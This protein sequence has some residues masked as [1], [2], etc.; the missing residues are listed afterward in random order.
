M[1][2]RLSM[3]VG[4]PIARFAAVRGQAAF[5]QAPEI[6]VEVIS[7]SNPD[8]ELGQKKQL[9]FEA[10]AEEVW[11]CLQDGRMEFYEPSQPDVPL[12]VSP[13]C[14]AFPSCN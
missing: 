14:P 12:A 10:G 5:E 1:A 11:F 4:T 13:R 6:C 2:S 7:P 8:S 9:Y 3:S